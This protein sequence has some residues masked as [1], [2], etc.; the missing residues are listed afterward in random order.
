MRVYSRKTVVEEVTDGQEEIS[1]EE[2]K[3][4][5]PNYEVEDIIEVEVTPKDFGRIAA[6][7]AKQDVTQRVREAERG[8]IL[9]EYEDREEDVMTGIIQRVDSNFVYV[10]LGKIEAKLAK[11]EQVSTEEYNVHDRIKVY[12]NKVEN[13]SKGP[14]ILISR[15]HPGLLKRL[16]EM[17]VPEIYDGTVEVKSISRE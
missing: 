2:A 5:D 11:Q 17:E 15:A 9:S 10:D 16:F 3:E 8:V 6:Q 14:Q 12:V 4:I 1:L 7:A 13:T